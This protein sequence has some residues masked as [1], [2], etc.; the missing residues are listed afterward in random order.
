MRILPV[1]IELS[2]R[3]ERGRRHG[4]HFLDAVCHHYL[5][6]GYEGVAVRSTTVLGA[7]E[8]AVDLDTGQGDAAVLESRDAHC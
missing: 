3:L 1:D 4:C 5:A 8:L 6:S 2:A 7:G